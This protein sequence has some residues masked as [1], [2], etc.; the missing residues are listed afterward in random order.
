M[1]SVTV[2]LAQMAPALYEVDKNLAAMARLIEQASLRQ[3]VDLFVFPEL[4]TTGYECGTRFA[5][6]AERLDGRSVESVAELATRYDTC[7]AFGLPERQK[8]ESV[9]YSAGVLVDAQGEVALAQEEVHLKAEQR[10]AL[11]PGFKL[12]VGKTR[13]G[14]VGL[15][16]GWDLAFPE[17]ARS[18]ALDGAELL[19][20]LGS[21]ERPYAHAWRS[22]LFA[23]AYENAV[24]VAACNRVGNEP[25]YAFCGESMV[26]GP[27]GAV[28]GRAEGAEPT[29]VIATID[30]D[31][32]R[33]AQEDT[34][35]LQARQPR[36]YR[37]LV[38]MY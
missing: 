3:K 26:I 20:V 11:R 23:R 32:V 2:A 12:P 34:Q 24:C 30:L 4:T 1:R 36:S 18:L 37:Q 31:E 28:Q 22:L 19:C 14:Q 35:L 17:A 33:A 15:L 13:F 38:K 21:W 6:L 10:L 8:V 9:I 7:I 29:L 5:D 27:L 25:S 16:V